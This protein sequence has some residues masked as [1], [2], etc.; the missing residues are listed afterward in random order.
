MSDDDPN[1]WGPSEIPY[2]VNL[3]YEGKAYEGDVHKLLELFCSQIREPG[4]PLDERLLDYVTS[5]FRDYLNGNARTLD[6]AF[7]EATRTAKKSNR[8]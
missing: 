5:A 2:R 1:D 4:R 6:H 7:G 8:A 3:I